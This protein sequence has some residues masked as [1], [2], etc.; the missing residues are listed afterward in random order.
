MKETN[1]IDENKRLKVL[2]DIYKNENERLKYE[3]RVLYD[4]Y[5]FDTDALRKQVEKYEYGL[6]HRIAYAI[7]QSICYKLLRKIKHIFIKKD[8]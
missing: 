6:S 5:M 3:Y 4:R 8:D 2:A 7:K 1:I